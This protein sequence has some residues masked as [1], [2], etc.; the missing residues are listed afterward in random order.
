MCPSKR[1]KWSN[2]RTF[3]LVTLDSR[4]N[5][6][7]LATLERTRQGK[8]QKVKHFQMRSLTSQLLHPPREPRHNGTEQRC[9]THMMN[10][11]GSL[12]VYGG[13]GGVK[14]M[15]GALNIHHGEQRS[16]TFKK[17]YYKS[18]SRRGAAWAVFITAADF[19]VWTRRPI[20]F[21]WQLG[22]SGKHRTRSSSGRKNNVLK[23]RIGQVNY[24]NLGGARQHGYSTDKVM[25]SEFPSQSLYCNSA[26]RAFVH[27]GWYDSWKTVCVCILETVRLCQCVTCV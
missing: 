19:F 14:Q 5:F 15:I 8:R 13:G 9:S 3:T 24:C 21:V 16:R 27:M 22:P 17:G 6:T 1:F 26:A 4:N 7:L 11:A 10:Q 18:R 23:G 12:N 20:S 2:R 25:S